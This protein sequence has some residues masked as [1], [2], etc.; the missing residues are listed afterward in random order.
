M[1]S[2]DSYLTLSRGSSLSI[3]EAAAVLKDLNTCISQ[4][5]ADDKMDFYNDCLRKAFQYTSIRCDWELMSREEKI[6]KDSYRT[7]CHDSFI[8]SLN[9]LSR[10]AA[11]EGVD[12]SW[13]EQLG[14]DRKR[15]G[16]FACYL[17]YINGISNR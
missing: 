1:N 13:R 10:L 6:D 4:V 12:T 5:K 16:D 15:I 7:A 9:I 3:E 2:Y 11:N 8:I 17:T 14:E